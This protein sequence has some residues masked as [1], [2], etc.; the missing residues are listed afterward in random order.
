MLFSA[1]FNEYIDGRIMTLIG[2]AQQINLKTENLQLGHVQQFQYRC[3]PKGK[4]DFIEKIFVTCAVTQT[5]IFVNTKSFAA[6]VARALNK[7]DCHAD[8][9][10]GATEKDK[11]D[12]IIEKFRSGEI[13]VLV[14]TSMLARGLDIPDV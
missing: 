8:L 7:K 1:T 12:E 3:E 4:I 10:D 13:R 5:I 2:E 11:R 14:T 9:I 6:T